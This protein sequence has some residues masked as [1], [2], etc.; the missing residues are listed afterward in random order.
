ML[1]TLGGLGRMPDGRLRRV[2]LEG[3]VRLKLVILCNRRPCSAACR[4][5]APPPAREPMN[6]HARAVRWLGCYE[7]TKPE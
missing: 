7:L 4:L 6:A 1:L 5:P 2:V 3:D